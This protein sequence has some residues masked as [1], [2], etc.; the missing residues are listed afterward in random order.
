MD[1]LQ[2]GSAR[3]PL[4]ELEVRFSRSSGPGG[5]NVNKRDTRVEIVFDIDASPSLSEMLKRRARERLGARV[6][7]GRIRVTSGSART[8]GE[9][10]RL[11]IERLSAL[12]DG[13][14]RPP[15]KPRRATRPSLA[16]KERRITQK[17]A[18]GQVK[19]ARRR[20]VLEDS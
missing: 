17:K 20:P 18:R 13:A 4:A 12:L 3:V 7:G 14:L 5:Q 1:D 9:N 15:P 10:R 8:Q 16:S 6:H 11:A 19:R 2:A